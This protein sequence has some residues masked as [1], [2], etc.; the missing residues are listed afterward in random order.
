M[1]SAAG[2]DLVGTNELLDDTHKDRKPDPKDLDVKIK[3]GWV[4]GLNRL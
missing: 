3:V 4:K 2:G 1:R